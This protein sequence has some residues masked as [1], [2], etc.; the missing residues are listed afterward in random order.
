MIEFDHARDY[1]GIL[2]AL[3]IKEDG[4]SDRT[5]EFLTLATALAVA[6]V[7]VSLRT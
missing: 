4:M 2:P 6:Q 7:A 5:S 1:R 3:T